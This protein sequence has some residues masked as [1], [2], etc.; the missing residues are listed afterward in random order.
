MSDRFDPADY[1]LNMI[2]RQFRGQL[3]R[4]NKFTELTAYAQDKGVTSGLA[5]ATLTATIDG[6]RVVVSLTVTPPADP[7]EAA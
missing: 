4:H 3:L 1:K 6:Y 2:V 7:E 5:C